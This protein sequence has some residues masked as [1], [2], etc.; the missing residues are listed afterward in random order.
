MVIPILPGA[1][2]Q[3]FWIV[4]LGMLFLGRWPNGRGPA[5]SVVEAVPWP[6]AADV[7]AAREAAAEPEEP[8]AA[9]PRR[10]EA[11]RPRKR[12]RR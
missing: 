7:Q 8:T 12:K 3:L 11:A 5:W 9:E 1:F 4:A 6:T 2:V 10:E